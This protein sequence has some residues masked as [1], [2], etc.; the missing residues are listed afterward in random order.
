MNKVNGKVSKKLYPRVLLNFGIFNGI[1][2]DG[3][4]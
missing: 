4:I 3:Q 2:V 1:F